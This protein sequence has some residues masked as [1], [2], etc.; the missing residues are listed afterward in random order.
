MTKKIMVCFSGSWSVTV[1]IES[2]LSYPSSNPGQH[3]LHF[4]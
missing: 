1:I 2:G 3:C 4:T